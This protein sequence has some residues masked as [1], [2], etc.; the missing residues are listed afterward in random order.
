MSKPKLII[1]GNPDLKTLSKTLENL[2]A[3]TDAL[4]TDL[5]VEPCIRWAVTKITY[6]CDGC[7]IERPKNAVGWTED[8][9]LDWCPACSRPALFAEAT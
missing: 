5:S 6:K 7:E 2:N 9:G 4:A 8:Q 1:R 3:L